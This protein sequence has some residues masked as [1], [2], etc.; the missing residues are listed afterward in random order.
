MAPKNIRTMSGVVPTLRSGDCIT[1]LA[2]ARLDDMRMDMAANGDETLDLS[3]QALWIDGSPEP[4]NG[5]NDNSRDPATDE[6]SRRGTVLCILRLPIESLLLAPPMTSHA[7]APPSRHWIQHEIDF[8]GDDDGGSLDRYPTTPDVIVEY[9]Q[10]RTL[11]IDTTSSETSS[12]PQMWR[13]LVSNMNSVVG[14]D[15]FVDLYCRKGDP[16][17]KLAVFASNPEERAGEWLVYESF[18]FLMCC[19]R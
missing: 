4:Q 12:N 2:S 17:L 14:G 8:T 7:P 3:I 1:L 18:L 6:P 16:R 19:T 15:A 5:Q 10:P 11:T 9:R 13:E